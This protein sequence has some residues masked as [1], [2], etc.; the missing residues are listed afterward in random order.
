MKKE[1]Y[2]KL[3]E[4][5]RLIYDH[6]LAAF[7]ENQYTL[8]LEGKRF[9]NDN[10]INVCVTI[11]GLK[12]RC[13]VNENNYIAWY[14]G[15]PMND[16]LTAVPHLVRKICAQ[17]KRILREN[18]EVYRQQRIEELQKELEELTKKC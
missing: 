15:W 11:C 3:G 4:L 16:L 8:E 1:D 13:A 14:C 6:L 10:Y 18:E 12:L 7:R 17:V 5:E 2:E 9:G